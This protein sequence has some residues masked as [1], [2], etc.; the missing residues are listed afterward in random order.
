MLASGTSRRLK[1][2][3][4]SSAR[5]T[6]RPA[7]DAFNSEHVWSDA[8]WV[9]MLCRWGTDAHASEVVVAVGRCVDV[10]GGG[11]TTLPAAAAVATMAVM[12]RC[13]S[14]SRR[15]RRDSRA[16]NSRARTASECS[17][18][19]PSRGT[20]A[21]AAAAAAAAAV[22][23]VVVTASGAA[24]AEAAGG[25][26]TTAEGAVVADAAA[27]AAAAASG[28]RRSVCFAAALRLDVEADAELVC[29]STQSPAPDATTRKRSTVAQSP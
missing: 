18:G 28:F 19:I 6:N 8:P 9:C 14:D 4:S 17:G 5:A 3:A 27:A 23:V 7:N 25:T 11:A 26:D 13:S 20:P 22:V 1:A 15:P 16:C 12:G 21:A 29:P 24:A 2:S 10:G